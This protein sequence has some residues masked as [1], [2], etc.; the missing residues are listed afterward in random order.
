MPNAKSQLPINPMKKSGR[1]L[2][3]MVRINVVMDEGSLRALDWI[4]AERHGVLNRSMV[5]RELAN[6]EA[7]R[8][9]KKGSRG[10]RRRIRR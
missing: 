5:I 1:K 3:G 9:V 8:Q 7:D 10:T 4:S 2:P 6:E